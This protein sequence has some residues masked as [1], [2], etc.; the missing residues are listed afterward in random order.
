[1]ERTLFSID[2]AQTIRLNQCLSSI[3][4][5]IYKNA[6]IGGGGTPPLYIGAMFFVIFWDVAGGGCAL[7]FLAPP[8]NAQCIVYRGG[9]VPPLLPVALYGKDLN[10]LSSACRLRK[11][12][13]QER[14]FAECF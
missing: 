3:Y 5:N 10:H 9:D 4:K 13:R 12:T 7:D 1:M 6:Q 8:Y 2:T 14:I 11:P